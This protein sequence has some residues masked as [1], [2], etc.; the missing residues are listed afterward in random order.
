ML[1]EFYAP[2]TQS[3]VVEQQQCPQRGDAAL[4]L[5]QGPKHQRQTVAVREQHIG[6]ERKHGLS[7]EREYMSH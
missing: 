1:H 2:V 5:P 4:M 7:T 3:A 6:V